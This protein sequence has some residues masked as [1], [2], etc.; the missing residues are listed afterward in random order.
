MHRDRQ[1]LRDMML[2]QLQPGFLLSDPE[3]SISQG[4]TSCA[5]LQTPSDA[6]P[7]ERAKASPAFLD[8][9][10]PQ[11]GLLEEST[12]AGEGPFWVLGRWHTQ[13]SDFIP[14]QIDQ[15]WVAVHILPK[16]S[17]NPLQGYRG[18][19]SLPRALEA[20][21]F[22]N[23]KGSFDNE[24][25]DGN[26]RL[27]CKVAILKQKAHVIMILIFILVLTGRLPEGSHRPNGPRSTQT[28]EVRGSRGVTGARSR[29]ARDRTG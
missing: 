16:P 14:R 6:Q 28:R 18:P 2:W 11:E 15:Q 7:T 5:S 1:Q 24:N 21:F 9:S 10:R 12:S 29:T 22:Q 4:K 26:V 3:I 23:M 19:D 17:L 20:N 13:I 27:E 25:S 8:S